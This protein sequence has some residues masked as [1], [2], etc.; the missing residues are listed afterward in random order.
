MKKTIL[1]LA[2]FIAMFSYG[3][4]E[5]TETYSASN[6][7][8]YKVGDTITLG[9]GSAPNGDFNYL[10]QGGFGNTMAVIGGSGSGMMSGN[11][12]QGSYNSGIDRNY[13]NS[14]VVLKKIK[15]QKNKRG[16]N[17]AFF[18]VGAGAMTNLNLHI[19]DAI[20]TCEVKDCKKSIQNVNVVSA[21][22][23]YDKL[24]KIKE[25]KD[26]GI[27]SEEEY[28]KEKEKIMNGN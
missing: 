14:N 26:D 5:K 27:L 21:D 7:V 2:M 12:N 23:K 3:Q 28:Q 1:L 11:K 15:Y 16:T 9:R 25:L 10:Q 18:V 19:E 13:S 6:G 24:K 17:K 4:R 22:G 8:V 20:E